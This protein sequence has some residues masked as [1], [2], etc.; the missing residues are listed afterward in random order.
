MNNFPDGGLIRSELWPR[1]RGMQTPSDWL[2]LVSCSEW[3]CEEFK[4]SGDK[5]ILPGAS[6]SCKTPNHKAK[7]IVFPV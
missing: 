7:P 2:G 4:V 1:E 3:L 5:N 6:I